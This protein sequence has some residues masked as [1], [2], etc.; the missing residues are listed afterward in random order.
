MKLDLDEDGLVEF[1]NFHHTVEFK[2]FTE[3]WDSKAPSVG[4]RWPI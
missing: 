2:T 1:W 3:N 4:T